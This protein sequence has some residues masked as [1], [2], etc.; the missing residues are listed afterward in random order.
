MSD[1]LNTPL[2]KYYNSIGLNPT[3]VDIVDDKVI[4]QIRKNRINLLSQTLKL[5]LSVLGKLEI[6]EFGPSSGDNA[7]ILAREGT[8]F[9]FCEPLD[10]LVE[11]LKKNFASHGLTDQIIGID[12]KGVEDFSHNK[13]YPIVIAEGFVH[14]LDDTN[15]SCEKMLNY[16]EDEGLLLIS[17]VSAPGTFIEYFKRFFIKLVSFKAQE[18]DELQIAKGIF[19]DEFDKINHSRSFDQWAF[20]TISNPLYKPSNFTDL[21]DLLESLPKNI[22]LHSSWPNVDSPDTFRWHKNI[23]S[24]E[25]FRKH[26]I[27]GYTKRFHHYITGEV[28]SNGRAPLMD[29]KEG[30]RLRE[31]YLEFINGIEEFIENKNNDISLLVLK[32]NEITNF[33]GTVPEAKSLSLLMSDV[34]KLLEETFSANES[35]IRFYSELWSG[36]QELHSR[37]GTP[38]HY[39]VFRKSN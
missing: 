27:E 9:Y 29:V 30:T 39:Y 7:I 24:N 31:L 26:S 5:P 18:E 35:N 21:I 23:E 16:V 12:V 4:S 37:W 20:D 1:E 3:G 22:L 34:K 2:G 19:K 6:L 36:C 8:K 25:S 38:G 32:I 28:F 10:Y 17:I 13:K 11:Q 14:F 33:L 15:G